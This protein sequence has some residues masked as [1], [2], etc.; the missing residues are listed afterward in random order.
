MSKV[1]IKQGYLF[2]PY[3][4]KKSHELHS[5]NVYS[6]SKDFRSPALGA[7]PETST[8]R[9]VPETTDTFPPTPSPKPKGRSVCW[10]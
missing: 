6:G 10:S 5:R 2:E 3:I 8:I 1:E 9:F 7:V 4:A